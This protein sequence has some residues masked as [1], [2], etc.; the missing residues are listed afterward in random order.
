MIQKNC[1]SK[2]Y[3][4]YTPGQVAIVK[5]QAWIVKFYDHIHR[6]AQLLKPL[7]GEV[8]ILLGCNVLS[9]NTARTVQ[10][11]SEKHDSSK[12]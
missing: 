2:N 8:M 5:F 4:I 9:Y 11:W 6:S 12:C 1:I 7:T 10:E 3:S